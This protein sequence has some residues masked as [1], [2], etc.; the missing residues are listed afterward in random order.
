[1]PHPGRG[2]FLAAAV[3]I[4][5]AGINNNFSEAVQANEWSGRIL[6]QRLIRTQLRAIEIAFFSP[7]PLLKE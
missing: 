6:I 7:R 5:A 1:M 2:L 4:L 3:F